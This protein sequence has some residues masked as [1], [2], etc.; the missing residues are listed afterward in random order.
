MH[1]RG[2]PMRR[3]TRSKITA[4]LA[5]LLGL[6]TSPAMAREPIR[7]LAT[8][9]YATTLQAI[10]APFKAAR[11][12]DLQIVI[13]NAGGVAARMR[14]GDVADVVM[15]SSASVSALI[16]QGRLAADGIEIGRM[17]LGMAIP[18]G[19]ATPD[20][21]SVE[22]FRAALLSAT[23]I[24]YIDPKGGGTSGP[25][26]ERM[27]A[28]MGVLDAVHAKAI[29]CSDGAAVVASVGSGG[30]AIGMTQASEII[31]G[32]NVSFAGYLPEQ[33]NVV[34]IYSAALTTKATDPVGASAFLAFM[35]GSIG[36]D[37]LRKAGWDLD[38]P[39][40]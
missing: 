11:G 9:V 14:A 32:Q 39:D 24:A 2:V 20:L 5:L 16:K 36:S 19:A 21:A 38:K 30:A 37:R 22:A 33:L 12:Y 1:V 26:F 8:G 23:R 25:L 10:E 6:G 31:G 15:S 3:A 40:D 13:D 34:T 35:K 27:F 7:V 28:S 29:L 17:R 18:V 4:A